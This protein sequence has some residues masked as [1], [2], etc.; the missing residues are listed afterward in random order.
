MKIEINVSEEDLKK[1]I[2]ALERYNSDLSSEIADTD[3]KD[4]RDDLK[5]E[6]VS[7]QKMIDQL[8]AKNP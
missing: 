2:R 3:S 1:I 6:R 4:F 8:K 7:I 5:N